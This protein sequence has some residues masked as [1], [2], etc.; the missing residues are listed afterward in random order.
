MDRVAKQPMLH[1]TTREEK[2]STLGRVG[3]C[4][5]I[6]YPP[7]VFHLNS[8]GFI[9][10]SNSRLQNQIYDQD[11]TCMFT[12]YI[13]NKGHFSILSVR[14]SAPPRHFWTSG[15]Q[16]QYLGDRQACWVF[17]LFLTTKCDVTNSN[18]ITEHTFFC[19]AMLKT[20]SRLSL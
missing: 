9:L 1:E 18:C 16:R 13:G 20:T 5:L 7:A 12:Y 17:Y 4:L 8:T 19:S 6:G 11:T 14:V 3:P 15:Y 10:I 2:I